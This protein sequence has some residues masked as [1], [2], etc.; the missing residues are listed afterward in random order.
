[1]VYFFH[2]MPR[3]ATKVAMSMPP[4]LYRA[5]E[6]IRKRTGKSRSAVMQEALRLWLRQQRDA[7]LVRQYE[8]GYRAEPESRREIEMAEAA[9]RLL[10]SQEW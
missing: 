5:V 4:D 8:S 10:S 9:V 2:T 3:L 7:V 1:M 6:H